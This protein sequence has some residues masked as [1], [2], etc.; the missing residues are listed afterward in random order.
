MTLLKKFFCHLPQFDPSLKYDRKKSHLIS[1]LNFY[2]WLLKRVL[3]ASF[4]QHLPF[5]C[6]YQIIP[7]YHFN[8]STLNLMLFNEDCDSWRVT[9]TFTI[10][11][12]V[13]EIRILCTKLILHIKIF[14]WCYLFHKSNG[15]V[16][17]WTFPI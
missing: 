9:V 8:C 16:L 6:S 10:H 2:T 14:I 13:S 1:L 7:I 12:D 5:A 3:W 15:Y 11:S 17:I 4:K